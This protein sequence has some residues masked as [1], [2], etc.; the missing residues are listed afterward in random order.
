M[1]GL[2]SAGLSAVGA[3]AGGMAARGAASRAASSATRGYNQATGALQ[4]GNGDA[5]GILQSYSDQGA[6]ARGLINAALGVP[7]AQGGI[8]QS[9]IATEGQIY[10]KIL[11]TRPDVQAAMSQEVNN[12]KSQLYGMSPEQAAKWWVE[13][14]PDGRKT[15]ETVKA[16]IAKAAPAAATPA[17]QTQADANKVFQGTNYA[18]DATKYGTQLTANAT[19]LGNSLW[20][21]IGGNRATYADSPWQDMSNRATTQANDLFLGLAGGSGSALSGRTLRGLQENQAYI[22]D[23]FHSNYLNAYNGAATGQYN[24][25]NTAATGG[26]NANTSAFNQWMAGLGGVADTGYNADQTVAGNAVNQGT[27]QANLATGNANTQANAQLAQGQAT[28]SMYS[29]LANALGQGVQA[30]S[31]AGGVS[32]QTQPHTNALYTGST[33]QTN[34]PVRLRNALRGA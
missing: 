12:R 11:E 17:P 25:N 21:P 34:G 32:P 1:L 7:Q 28:Q 3:V 33:H 14:A 29:G 15:F 8:S 18:K 31:G 26:Y 27:Q 16:S 4:H 24:A 20:Q 13:N 19:E 10:Q 30:L 6:G 5:A 22:D 9:G 2:L 23:S